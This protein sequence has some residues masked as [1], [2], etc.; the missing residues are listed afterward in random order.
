M[1]QALLILHVCVAK[2]RQYPISDAPYLHPHFCYHFPASFS[3]VISSPLPL[4]NR[5][6]RHYFDAKAL[7]V[8]NALSPC[9]NLS[10]SVHRLVHLACFLPPLEL[11]LCAP[12]GLRF[13]VNRAGVVVMLLFQ[14][15]PWCLLSWQG[16][17]HCV[18]AM[19]A[20]TS[21]FYKSPRSPRSAILSPPVP[22]SHKFYCC[23]LLASASS[24]PPG[25]LV[26]YLP[27]LPW[28]P[29]FLPRPDKA[30]ASQC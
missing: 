15:L 27:W 21:H 24:F 2:L 13:A 28:L 9:R 25:V 30:S 7:A 16:L 12:C 19:S 23:L 11:S 5:C 6:F 14:Q 4:S 22:L 3:L 20:C 8:I 1:P 29:C 17:H 18:G 10:V 26:F